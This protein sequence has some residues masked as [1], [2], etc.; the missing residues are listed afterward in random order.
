MEIA[1]EPCDFG[2][3]QPFIGSNS[4]LCPAVLG[5][6]WPAAR[7][8]FERAEAPPQLPVTPGFSGGEPSDFFDAAVVPFEAVVRHEQRGPE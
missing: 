2:R 5:V 4:V 1:I 7:R 6:E 3:V 8:V